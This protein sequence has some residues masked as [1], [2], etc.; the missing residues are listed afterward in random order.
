M[1]QPPNNERITS[2]FARFRAES[3]RKKQNIAQSVAARR[4]ICY[5]KK[6]FDREMN[7]YAV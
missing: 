3:C 1:G 5:N 6:K 2:L 7:R 4:R